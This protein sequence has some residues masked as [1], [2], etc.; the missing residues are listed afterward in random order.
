MQKTLHSLILISALS[1]S[2]MAEPFEAESIPA[3]QDNELKDMSDLMSIYTQAGIGSTSKGIN[4]KVGR[5]YD[6]GDPKTAAMNLVEIKG[7]GGDVLAWGS[8]AGATTNSV[9]SIRI[10]NY[11]VNVTTQI[12]SQLDIQYDLHADY[13]ILSYSVLTSMIPEIWRFKFYPLVGIGA[14]VANNL[15]EIDPQASSGFSIPGVLGA[16]ALYAKFTITDK[17]WLNYNP[18]WSIAL[19][20]SD[21]FM[22]HGL[23]GRDRLYKHEFAAS[24]QINPRLNIRFFNDWTSRESFAD[25]IHRVEFNYQF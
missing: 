3:K 6:T 16:L 10:R 17:I 13:G 22:E 12:G 19:A 9:D 20:G 15:N 4:I 7:A 11:S 25:G 21:W 2:V 23:G 8:S 14:A 5:T 1:V 24:Y 18:N